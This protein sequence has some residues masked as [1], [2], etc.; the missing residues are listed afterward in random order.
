[1]SWSIDVD[2][3][4]VGPD[5]MQCNVLTDSIRKIVNTFKGMWVHHIVASMDRK[6]V[7]SF[8]PDNR[9]AMRVFAKFTDSDQ[10]I[11]KMNMV[12]GFQ[13]QSMTAKWDSD[14]TDA[15]PFCGKPD[16]R[17]HRLL[18]CPVND[19]IK[20]KFP[21][22]CDTLRTF[23]PEWIYIAFPRQH[24]MCLLPRAFLKT[25]KPPI[26]PSAL[27]NGGDKLRFFTDG[28]A[29][30]P[31]CAAARIASWSV[32]QDTAT[33]E[34]QM[35]DAANFLQGPEP[36]FPCFKVAALGLVN[37]DQTA[38]RGELLALLTAAKIA[39]K[40]SPVR[41]TEFVVDASYVFNVVSFIQSGLWSTCGHKLPNIDLICE[42]AGHWNKDLFHEPQI[43]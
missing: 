26:I 17:E 3:N 25:I 34:A 2:G 15:R 40:Y 23:R 27:F 29:I 11:L 18:E 42:L 10:H 43:F 1:M 28:G 13:T 30:H 21:A 19:E 24:D 12:G 14:V 36:K 7:G 35:K 32:V 4:I 20:Q 6:G 8:I 9:L 38:S 37:G 31:T 39:S 41:Y 5:H 22:A 33:S 16:T